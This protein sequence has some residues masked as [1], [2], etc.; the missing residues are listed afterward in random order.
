MLYDN[1]YK[2]HLGKL[3][4]HRLGPFIVAEIHKSDIV[5][6]TQLDSILRLVWVNGAHLKPYI[7][8]Q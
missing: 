3:Q 4:M 2:K 6:L 1:K 5:K 7:F 8:S